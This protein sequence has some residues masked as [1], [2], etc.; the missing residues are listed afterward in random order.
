M[1]QLPLHADGPGV[2]HRGLPAHWIY[3]KIVTLFR[4]G[5]H[6]QQWRHVQEALKSRANCSLGGSI[7]LV[8]IA[9]RLA[10]KTSWHIPESV[11]AIELMEPYLDSR[12]WRNCLTCYGWRSAGAAG[13]RWHVASCRSPYLL[14]TSRSPIPEHD[15]PAGVSVRPAVS[16]AGKQTDAAKPLLIAFLCPGSRVAMSRNSMGLALALLLL[17]AAGLRA[18]RTE[19]GAA[20]CHPG[21]TKYG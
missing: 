11:K 9:H 17:A 13:R 10:V 15:R 16:V 12:T 5:T 3:F 8:L 14:P 21:C 18:E 4:E 6:E 20:V 2:R 1:T 19:V 7:Q